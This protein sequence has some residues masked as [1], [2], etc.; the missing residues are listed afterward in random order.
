MQNIYCVLFVSISPFQDTELR[1][2]QR[3]DSGGASEDDDDDDEEDDDE[4]EEEEARV[5][6]P[7]R[8]RAR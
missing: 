6:E 1:A 4:E 7:P 8:K 3:E 5:N 2:F